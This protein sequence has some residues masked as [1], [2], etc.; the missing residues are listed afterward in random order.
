MYPLSIRSV[1]VIAAVLVAGAASPALS[2]TAPPQTA[3]P[4]T[5]SGATSDA[6]ARC[7]QLITYFDR[8]GASRGEHSDGARNMTRIAAGIDC[9]D[10]HAE[11][12]LHAMENLLARKKFSVPPTT[13]L[14][15][16]P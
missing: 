8:Y 11:E 13:G 12:G 5:T 14:A 9:D 7:K 4:A 10:G 2:Q 15:H 6:K 16:S 1:C 3:T